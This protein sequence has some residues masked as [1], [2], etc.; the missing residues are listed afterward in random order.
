MYE[1]VCE[2]NPEVKMM[3]VEDKSFRKFGR[4]IDD[5]PVVP[6][7]EVWQDIKL[8]SEGTVYEASVPEWEK[9]QWKKEFEE[10]YFG[11]L[12]IQAGY[13]AGDNQLLNGLEYHKSSEIVV[14]AT[15]LVL[16]VCSLQDQNLEE[17]V[18][19]RNIQ[20]VY[21]PENTAVELYS[22]TLHLAPCRV[23]EEPFKSLILLPKGTNEELPEEAER[24]RFLFKK[25]KWLIA[26]PDCKRFTDQGVEALIEGTN[27]QIRQGLI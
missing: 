4:L 2:R 18:H 25:N 22:T 11:S 8:P 14:A 6:W 13:C 19:S 17:G 26:H 23:T 16:L 27:I 5:M 12:E 24:S 15:P 3:H 7:E 21:I 1:R 10:R 20:G 9:S